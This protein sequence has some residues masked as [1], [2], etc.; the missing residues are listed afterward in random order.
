M[1][2]EAVRDREKNGSTANLRLSFAAD[3]AGIGCVGA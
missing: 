1:F 2:S 3:A